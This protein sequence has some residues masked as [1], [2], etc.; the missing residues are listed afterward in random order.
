MPT[1][2][3]QLVGVFY[4]VYQELGH[5]FLEHTYQRAMQIAVRQCGLHCEREVPVTVFFRG[6]AVG[7]YRADL[8]VAAA[9]IIECK[10]AVKIVPAHQAQLLNYLKASEY[11]VGLILNFG[12]Q[13]S[14][15]RMIYET[16]R[17]RDCG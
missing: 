3:R 10:T 2:G 1:L 15:K 9:V 8:V 11:N 17:I 16:A 14:F 13:P 7:E 4:D 5:G 12:V 6:E